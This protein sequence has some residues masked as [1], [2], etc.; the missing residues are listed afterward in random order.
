MSVTQRWG[1]VTSSA[2]ALHTLANFAVETLVLAGGDAHL[3]DGELLPATWRARVAER[4]IYGVDLDPLAVALA[5]ST[6]WLEA[7]APGAPAPCT[8]N[9]RCGNSLIGI[10]P[11]DLESLQSSVEAAIAARRR[12]SKDTARDPG[13]RLL[14]RAAD[15]LTARALSSRAL[16]G[17]LAEPAQPPAC[18]HWPLEFP[19]VFVTAPPAGSGFDVV[20]GNPPYGAA[21]DKHEQRYLNRRFGLGSTDTAALIMARAVRLARAGGDCGF[22]VPKPFTFASNWAG[23]RKL[24]LDDLCELV[25]AGKVWGDVKLEQVL[26]FQ[27]VGQPS[28]SYPSFRREGERF[29][30]LAQVQKSEC[31]RF[32]FLVNGISAEEMAIGRKVSAAGACLGDFTSNRR[33]G[34]HQGELLDAP[35]GLRAIGGKQVRRYGLAGQK[36]YLPGGVDLPPGSLPKPGS[37]LVQN[38]LAHVQQP[39]DHVLIIATLLDEEDANGIAILDTVNQLTNVSALP[40]E[41]LLGLLLSRLVNWYVYRFV[42][43]RAVRTMHFDGPA[44]SR[45][46]VPLIV[47]ADPVLRRS[48]QDVVEAVQALI[49]LRKGLAGRSRPS[50]LQSRWDAAEHSLDAAVYRLYGLDAR[51]IALVERQTPA[52]EL[53]QG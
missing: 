16:D 36:G 53:R 27:C 41:Y 30:P 2:N 47:E 3:P 9:L 14:R 50:R 46:P 13:S 25:D 19:E 52:G 32:G 23:V 4:C 21:L 20:L 8:G 12:R 17:G 7:T 24:L 45:I 28:G 49:A 29:V 31:R 42:F 34:P 39:V 11:E 44:S 37:I 6:V 10:A 48:R 5:R 51:E 18:F 33:G 40:G 26:Y 35:P 22:I 15:E 1:P 38:I 43:A